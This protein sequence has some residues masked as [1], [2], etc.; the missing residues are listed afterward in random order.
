MQVSGDIFS[1]SSCS[2][3]TSVSSNEENDSGDNEKNK[4]RRL[5]WKKKVKKLKKKIG[6]MSDG[7]GNGNSE[8]LEVCCLPYS[9]SVKFPVWIEK[10]GPWSS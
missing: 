9:F 1:S 2:S 5:K 3:L 4:K 6:E 10:V 8:T 7:N